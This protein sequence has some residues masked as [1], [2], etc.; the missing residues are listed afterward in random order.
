M[1]LKACRDT[2]VSAARYRYITS[3]AV[4]LQYGVIALAHVGDP[5]T[6]D[7]VIR[8]LQANGHRIFQSTRT[9]VDQAASAAPI[10]A[11]SGSPGSL[12]DAADRCLAAL[13][14]AFLDGRPDAVETPLR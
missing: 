9:A 3:L 8:C 13:D 4:A 7:A 11:A 14:A 1:P 5:S 12:L 2:I 10:V 6:G